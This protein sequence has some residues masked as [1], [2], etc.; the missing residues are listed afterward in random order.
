MPPQTTVGMLVFKSS[1]GTAQ[2]FLL[3][4]LSFNYADGRA[5]Y[6]ISLSRYAF[7]TI[8][9]IPVHY[10]VHPVDTAQLR[11]PERGPRFLRRFS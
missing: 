8:E 5:P 2:A 3:D 7:I 4:F 11:F 9:P 6:I 1:I 10:P